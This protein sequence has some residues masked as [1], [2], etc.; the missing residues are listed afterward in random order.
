MISYK[1]VERLN[2]KKYVY[3]LNIHVS[4]IIINVNDHGSP[5]SL[6]IFYLFI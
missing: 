4:L 2:K 5:K 3:R 6:Y 1:N